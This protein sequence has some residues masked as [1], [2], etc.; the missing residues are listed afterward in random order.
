MQAF[1]AKQKWET[2]LSGE[3]FFSLIFPVNA[4]LSQSMI[5]MITLGI[6]E[7]SMDWRGQ[8]DLKTT[9]FPSYLTGRSNQHW[10]MSPLYAKQVLNLKK[11]GFLQAVL[12]F[13][14]WRGQ[15]SNLDLRALS[16]LSYL[17]MLFL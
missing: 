15:E 8:Q 10:T 3:V 11:Q 4:Q 6:I 7:Y 12:M 16:Q 5:K 2:S 9:T 17:P 13:F 14:W 1:M